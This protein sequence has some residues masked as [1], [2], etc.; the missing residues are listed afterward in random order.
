MNDAQKCPRCG[1]EIPPASTG[2]VC[3]RCAAVFLQATATEASAAGEVKHAFIPPIPAELAGKFPQLEILGFIGQGGMGAVYKARQRELD[4]VVALKILPPDIGT[5]PAFAE[6]FAREAKAM[7]RLNHPGI[8][9]IHDFG[10]A[11]GLFYFLMEYVDGVSLGQ[12]MRTGRVSPREALAI[13]PQIC[14]A[15]QYAHDQGLV[16]R[17][18][19]PENILLDRGGRVKVADFGLVKLVEGSEAAIG[20]AT[21]DARS[22]SL[23]EAGKVMGTPRYMAPEQVERPAQ[24]DHRADIYAL[25][26][27]FYQM[28]TGELPGTP[29]APPSRK[30]HIDVRLDEVVLRA[31][32][33]EP[34][35]RYQQ[36]SQV[37]TFI[38]ALTQ[39][40][41]PSSAQGEAVTPQKP[42]WMTSVLSALA[43]H[44]WRIVAVALVSLGA[45]S[46]VRFWLFE[47]GKARPQTRTA[48]LSNPVQ[49][50][51]MPVEKGDIRVS[52]MIP[53]VVESSNLV[54]FP[55]SEAY[56]QNLMHRFNAG[57]NIEVR[58]YDSQTG[59]EF[60]YG[61]VERLGARIS[62]DTRTL[63]CRAHLQPVDGNLMVPG[64]G[65]DI[66]ITLAL[67]HG[68][69]RAPDEAISRDHS[70]TKVWVIRPDRTLA[71][72]PVQVGATEANV[73]VNQIIVR[74]MEEARATDGH[75]RVIF[76]AWSEIQ[77]GLEPGELVVV[78]PPNVQLHESQKV[79]YELVSHADSEAG[80]PEAE[81]GSRQIP[82]WT[83]QKALSGWIADLQN[84]DPGVR[85]LA[86]QAVAGMGTNS[87]PEF[88]TLLGDREQGI[89]ADTRRLNAA[90]AL[91]FIGPG[92]RSA[93]PEFV[94][95]LFSGNQESAY[96]GARALAFSAPIVPAAFEDLTNALLD[97]SPGVRDAATH[98]VSLILGSE[99][100]HVAES[101]LPLLLQNLGD[102]AQF[103]RADTASALM[104]YVQYQTTH[105]REAKPELIL[106]ALILLLDDNYSYAR[107]YAGMTIKEYGKSAVPV[108]RGLSNDP[109]VQV[110][111]SATKALRL[112][113]AKP[114]PQPSQPPAGP[115]PSAN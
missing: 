69:V 25:G 45:L 78:G 64:L 10:R 56:V 103:V 47:P 58:A 67:K 109:N 110:R 7:A 68:V 99:S 22:G 101:A 112:L 106:P 34:E 36:A 83:T 104:M 55:V 41:N 61:F 97:P 80:N 111:E 75:P 52:V 38:E 86:Q 84:P 43:A 77:S 53:G 65:L 70:T 26:V 96:A 6:R 79:T 23:T 24:V 87:L 108:L 114:L 28:L 15:L 35:R 85:K 16:H 14:D 18:I 51:A 5:D 91:G 73:P 46:G 74:T 107:D 9:T 50:R 76:G 102:H 90:A 49:V 88:L 81:G 66:R 44:P 72:R 93:I 60:G 62:E 40:A 29:L 54:D 32:E 89:E 3:P 82:D 27:V 59:R 92:L 95:L 57:Q 2:G 11:E 115:T 1:S 105:D 37:K 13:V 30:V 20:E 94:S 21:A 63:R 48:M 31:L 8:V 19:K 4:R 98:G 71:R 100:N 12:L 42:P 113:E 33:N 17:D 39:A